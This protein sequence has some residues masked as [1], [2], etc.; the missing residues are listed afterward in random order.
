MNPL[1][2]AFSLEIFA[3]A[4]LGDDPRKP[5]PGFVFL[6]N[7]LIT[8]V[9]LTALFPNGLK[10]FFFTSDWVFTSSAGSMLLML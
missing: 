7:G 6:A 1:S 9:F 8:L 10:A 2:I 4:A 3:L 5:Y